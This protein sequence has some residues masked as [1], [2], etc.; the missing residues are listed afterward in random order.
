MRGFAMNVPL[1]LP[2][3][4]LCLVIAYLV[5]RP[6]ARR[7]GGSPFAAFLL[8]ASLGVIVAATLT[9][10]S[11]ALAE[12]VVSS[13]MCDTRRLGFASLSVYLRASDTSLNVL[14]FVPL[15]VALGLMPSSRLVLAITVGAFALSPAIE[16]IQMSVPVLGRGC[17]TA[18]VFDNTFGLVLG[19]VAGWAL[20]RM[21]PA[22]TA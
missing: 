2:V 10:I 14:L 20:H 5:R 16:L 21:L 6:V 8:V 7:L 19:L 22:A 13:G 18:D 3:T 17:Q 9:P 11:E 15:G 1:F 12:G 4:A